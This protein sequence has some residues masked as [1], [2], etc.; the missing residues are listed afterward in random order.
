[1][2]AAYEAEGSTNLLLCDPDKLVIIGLDT[3]DGPEH[4]LYDERIKLAI[5][6][7]FIL[8][9]MHHGVKTP[10]NVVKDPET[11]KVLVKAGRQRVKAAREANKRLRKEGAEPILVKAVPERGFSDG[12]ALMESVEIENTFRQEDSPLTRAKK[13]QRYLER[14]R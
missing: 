1:S 6:E 9:I 5:P 4:P 2:K 7:E 8:Q 12:A 13:I 14:G 3:K 11:G 10:I